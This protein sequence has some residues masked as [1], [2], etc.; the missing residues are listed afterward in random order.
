MSDESRSSDE[1]EE[2]DPAVRSRMSAQD[3]AGE[4]TRMGIDPRS[5]GLEGPEPSATRDTHPSGDHEAAPTSAGDDPSSRIVPLR[6]EFGSAEQPT[7]PP[8]ATPQSPPAVTPQPPPANP[9]QRHLGPVE[10]MIAQTA[11]RKPA[12]RSSSRVVKALTF[13]LLTPDAAEAAGSERELVGALRQRQTERRIVAFVS[14]KGGVGT[15]TVACA[16]GTAL[17]ALRDDHTVLVDAQSGTPSLS[18]LHG[19]NGSMSGRELLA[20]EDEAEPVSTGGGLRLVDGAGW[21]RP[22][23]RNDLIGVLE[24]LGTD[25]AF[26]LVDAGRDSGEAAHTA[27]ARCDQAVIVTPVGEMGMAALDV[28]VTRLRQVN[29]L[30][31]ERAVYAVV[32]PHREAY[33]RAHREVVQRLAVEPARVVVVPPDETLKSGQVFDAAMAGAPTREAML[34]IAAALAM[35]GG[36]R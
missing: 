30:A 35:S 31:A 15:T 24:R 26:T 18:G 2:I 17:A 27:V 4:L 9:Q 34:E 14:G 28:A 10:Q 16:V 29:P 11:S 6:P 23:E 36:Q 5:L 3:A 7:P 21:G 20:A 32:C 1:S 8:V 12:P 25:N 22:L 19:L 33:R 13:G